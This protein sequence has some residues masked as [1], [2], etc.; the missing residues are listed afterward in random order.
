[1]STE[2]LLNIEN[3]ANLLEIA[4]KQKT[5]GGLIKLACRIADASRRQTVPLEWICKIHC[6]NINTNDTELKV[7][8]ILFVSCKM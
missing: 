5:F 6:E 4:H 2:N 1:M 3:A 8:D 7:N